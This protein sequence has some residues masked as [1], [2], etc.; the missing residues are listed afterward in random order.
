MKKDEDG[1]GRGRGQGRQGDGKFWKNL[2]LTDREGLIPS[3]PAGSLARGQ[4]LA[5]GT[6]QEQHPL[7]LH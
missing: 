7:G 5:G 4:V 3:D 6:M 2:A 1:R